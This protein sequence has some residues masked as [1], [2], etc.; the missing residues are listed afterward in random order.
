MARHCGYCGS[1]G[2]NRRTCESL[3]GS[4]SQRLENSQRRLDQN[5]YQ[6]GSVDE[7]RLIRRIANTAATL[8]KRTGTNPVTGEAAVKPTRR[9]RK[10][11]Y[12][13]S[14]GHDR[15]R[16]EPFAKDKLIWQEA[17]R[18]ARA[19]VARRVQELGVGIGTLY[20]TRTGYY[21]RDSSWQ[22]GPRPLIV[23]GVDENY[24]FGSSYFSFRG[25]PPTKL[26]DSSRNWAQSVTLSTLENI[27]RRLR[28]EEEKGVTGSEH[29]FSPTTPFTFSAS[30]LAAEDL[31]WTEIECFKKGKRRVYALTALDQEASRRYHSNKVLVAA[32]RNLGYIPQ[33]DAETS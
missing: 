13:N 18:I 27:A 26:M 7:L 20:V 23:M 33:E 19:D 8:A 12:C 5:H 3:T 1:R 4:L 22:Y 30:W 11:S 9:Q 16:C 10:C 2:H 14:I 32:A 24:H 6:T 31:P 25:V 28:E 17:T 15:R 29:E 21:N